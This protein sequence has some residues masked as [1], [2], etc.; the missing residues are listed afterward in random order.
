M[1]A[2]AIER[3]LKNF[4]DTIDEGTMQV[5]ESGIKFITADGRLRTMRAR[6]LVK[7]PR[8]QLGKPLDP[9]GGVTYNLK[10]NGV[11]MME[12][13]DKQEPRA[14]KVAMITELNGLTVFH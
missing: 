11:M 13:I 8:Q 4:D 14:V 12:D 6:K 9:R 5:R 7:A 3:V 10:R 1:G 2:I